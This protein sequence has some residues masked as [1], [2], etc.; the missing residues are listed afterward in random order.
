MRPERG[1]GLKGKGLGAMPRCCTFS[2]RSGWQNLVTP[3]TTRI[4]VA[5]RWGA[6]PV[7]GVRVTVRTHRA[8]GQPTLQPK[9]AWPPPTAG[10]AF[11]SPPP[12]LGAPP[13]GASELLLCPL[14]QAAPRP[15]VDIRTH[16][17]ACIL[18]P[19]P[20][21]GDKGHRGGE[22]AATGRHGCG[23]GG[24]RQVRATVKPAETRVP[25]WVLLV[26]ARVQGAQAH[27]PPS[28]SLLSPCKGLSH[29]VSQTHPEQTPGGRGRV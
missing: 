27:Q 24:G 25:E 1:Q 20:P 11:R 23:R 14:S 8:V 29:G 18:D 2:G 13:P 17:G 3:P 15:D 9:V 28:R 26:P 5:H 6:R 10:G 22:E 21:P 16:N 4:T 12:A 19:P 7:P